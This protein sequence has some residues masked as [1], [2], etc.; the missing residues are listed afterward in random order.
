MKTV[1]LISMLHEGADSNSGTRRFRNEPVL[2]WTLRRLSQAIGTDDVIVA[3]WDDQRVPADIPVRSFGPRKP[4][5]SLDA[6]TTAQKWSDGWRGGLLSTCA[7][8]RG[9]VPALAKQVVEETGAD[10]LI[11]IDPAAALI[12]PLVVDRV[13]ETAAAGHRDFYFTQAPPGLASPLLKKPLIDRLASGNAHPGRIVHYLPEAPLLDPITSDACVEL[14]LTVSRSID[15]FLLD[16][17]RQIDRLSV[18]TAPMNGQLIASDAETIATCVARSDRNGAFPREITIEMTT[19]RACS[20]VFAPTG[21]ERPD[22]PVELLERV[23]EQAVQ[24]DDVRV[25]LAGVGD[26]LLHPEIDRILDLCRSAPAVSV[27]TDL[28]ECPDTTLRALLG[29]D[30]IGVHL[31]AMSPGTYARIMG[32]DAMQTVVQNIQRLLTLRQASGRLTPILAPIFTKLASNLD[33]MEQWYDTWLRAVGSAVIVGP[34]TYA[35]LVAP[36]HAADMT[37]PLRRPCARIESRLTILSDGTIVACDQDVRGAN[38]M[39]H[40]ARD[41]IADV[42]RGAMGSL[43]STHRSLASLPVICGNCS[44]WHRP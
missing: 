42:W 15:R 6:I 36:T 24:H 8:D 13:I 27:E 35:G 20:P 1:A 38:P 18:A 5:P 17:A 34:S 21:I 37:P 25:C 12:D 40:I 14:P 16:S 31:P 3:T 4:I 23:L 2:T 39:G 29:I 10:A 41:A 22:M 26:P 7:F 32:R 43:R 28:I 9:F 30:V 44:E 11:L 33:E 19:R